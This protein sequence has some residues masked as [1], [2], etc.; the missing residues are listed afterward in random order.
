MT[1]QYLI[2]AFTS[3]KSN[4]RAICKKVANLLEA[5]SDINVFNT[6]GDMK[7]ECFDFRFSIIQKLIAEGWTITVPKN[8]Y[9][10]KAPRGFSA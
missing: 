6:E 5:L 2:P 7:N 3:N 10:V 1:R 4:T 8:K 9:V